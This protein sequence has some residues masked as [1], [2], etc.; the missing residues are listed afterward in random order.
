M[1]DF[2]K[3]TSASVYNQVVHT[4]ASHV[5]DPLPASEHVSTTPTVA[6]PT[7][8]SSR[9][10]HKHIA[11]KWVIPIVDMAD[12]AMIKFDSD[13]DSDDD[14]LH[15][16]P[17]AS[18]EMVSSPLGSVHAYHDM[19]GHTKHFTTLRELLYMV[20]KTNLQKFLGAVDELYQKED[21]DTFALIFW[22][23]LHV[24]F[25]SLKDEEVNDFWRN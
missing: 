15:Y 16:A 14:P 10:R 12:A 18:W 2:V 7:P 4:A 3:N 19:A 23:D 22:G 5:D 21:P 9:T 24:L 20:E 13:S 6:A 17:Y 11:K 8:S 1:R 25:Q